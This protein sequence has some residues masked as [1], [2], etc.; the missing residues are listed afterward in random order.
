[1]TRI[2]L[3]A[4]VLVA[5]SA[6]GCAASGG[7]PVSSSAS[8]NADAC[9]AVFTTVAKFSASDNPAMDFAD[10]QAA[11]EVYTPGTTGAVNVALGKLLGDI[12]TIDNAT[13]SA[14]LAVAAGAVTTDTTALAAAC[15]AS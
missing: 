7:A 8:A 6:A 4:V 15:Q 13:D 1:M 9:R 10:E 14:T 5:L 2:R 12:V 3:A 11:L